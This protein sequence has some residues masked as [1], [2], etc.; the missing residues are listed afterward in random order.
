MSAVHR[1]AIPLVGAGPGDPDLLTTYA[2]E[3]LAAS[4]TVL[5]DPAVLGL[6]RQVAPDAVVVA[7]PVGESV[8]SWPSDGGALRLYAGDGVAA[9]LADRHALTAAG[10]LFDLVPGVSG[11]VAA[12][13]L[14][15]VVDQGVGRGEV[16]PLAGTAVVVT[17]PARQAEALAAPLRRL[18]ATVLDVPTIRIDPPAD[19]G[20]ALDAAMASVGVYRWLIVT[21]ANGATAVLDR[22]P[23]VRVLAGVGIAAIGPATAATFR[24]GHVGVDLVPEEYVAESLLA[25]FPP[26]QPGARRVLVA[27]AAVARD[28]L[29]DGLRSAGWEVDVVEAYRTVRPPVPPDLLDR[30]PTADVVTFTSPST[31]EGFLAAIGSI[32]RVP[33]VVACI[34][35]VTAA[36]ARAAG[37]V[38][39]VVATT[40]TV[41]GLIDA[42]VA[43]RR[44]RR[45]HAVDA[46]AGAD[47]AEQAP[48]HR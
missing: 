30:V 18:G 21:S 36:A 3:L 8:G 19:G 13:A 48:S 47:A 44:E 45:A 24:D 11:D 39:D 37:L 28:V 29:P 27:R 10:V 46:D 20:R 42:L 35:P 5:A 41:D 31:V 43:H 26:A 16:R 9:S 14:D 32:D 34:G 12:V 40:F 25:A 33:A 7:V 15:L 17:R 38:V 4:R 6:A 1:A 22:L 23:D 2:R